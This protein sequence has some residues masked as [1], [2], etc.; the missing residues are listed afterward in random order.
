[1]RG[2]V[3]PPV[4]VILIPSNRDREAMHAFSQ[5]DN[6]EKCSQAASRWLH[7]SQPFPTPFFL[8]PLPRPLQFLRITP[9]LRKNY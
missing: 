7:A 3:Y 2:L 1:M 8:H 4:F 5:C 6:R 9:T